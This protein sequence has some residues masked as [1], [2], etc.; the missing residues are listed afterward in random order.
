MFKK[1]GL[2]SRD[3]AL[4]INKHIA[5]GEGD[6]L[7]ENQ[8]AESVNVYT[9]LDDIY[10]ELSGNEQTKKGVYDHDDVKGYWNNY[11]KEDGD[12]QFNAKYIHDLSLIHI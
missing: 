1:F 11:K 12:Q 8:T 5:P 6:T 3:V 7:K 10:K 9:I 4:Q 2:Q